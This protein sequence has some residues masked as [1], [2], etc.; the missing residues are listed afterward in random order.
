MIDDL[1]KRHNLSMVFPKRNRTFNIFL[2]YLNLV[3]T[4]SSEFLMLKLLCL[5]LT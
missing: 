2:A 3:F 1:M 4:E 5:R